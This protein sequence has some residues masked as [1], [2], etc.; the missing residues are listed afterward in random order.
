MLPHHAPH[1]HDDQA[2]WARALRASRQRAA[3]LYAGRPPG[4][5]QGHVPCP[6]YS[7][8]MRGT[9]P[10]ASAG[11]RRLR[12]EQPVAAL[13]ANELDVP[14]M[15]TEY[16]GHGTKECMSYSAMACIPRPFWLCLYRKAF[17]P[18]LGL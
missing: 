2:I 17:R 5:Q 3:G 10:K 13:L 4:N 12:L 15:P 1:L 18:P 16:R 7:V 11:T 8:G 14:L 9:G 6:R